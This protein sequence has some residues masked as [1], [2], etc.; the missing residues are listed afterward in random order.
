MTLTMPLNNFRLKFSYIF[1]FKSWEIW[2]PQLGRMA[3]PWEFLWK[4]KNEISILWKF[5]ITFLP[6][7]FVYLKMF[8][9]VLRNRRLVLYM[10]E[11]AWNDSSF[12]CTPLTT[13]LWYVVKSLN[14]FKLL[15]NHF[16]GENVEATRQNKFSTQVLF[17]TYLT[18]RFWFLE[19]WLSLTQDIS[20]RLNLTQSFLVYEHAT[21][22]YNILMSLSSELDTAILWKVKYKNVP[23]KILILD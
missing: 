6:I 1:F 9:G 11:P 19:G 13:W 7:K 23:L 12:N 17:C 21:G 8:S 4:V 18:T 16:S 22:A 5:K 15:H 20:I 14:L 2:L 10:W 3:D